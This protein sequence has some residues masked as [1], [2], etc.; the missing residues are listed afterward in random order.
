V[1]IDQIRVGRR[2]VPRDRAHQRSWL[3]WNPSS[4]FD[5]GGTERFM[6]FFMGLFMGLF[7]GFFMSSFMGLFMGLFMSSFMGFFMGD[8]RF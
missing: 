6:G 3:Q 7:M 4:R 1:S 5:A 8:G 2:G